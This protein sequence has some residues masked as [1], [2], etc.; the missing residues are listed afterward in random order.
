MFGAQGAANLDNI[1]DFSHAEGDKIDISALLG[2]AQ[3]TADSGSIANYVHFATSGN[4]L[5][6]Q[7]D[8]SGSGAF[9]GG[10]HDVVQLAAY[11]VSNQHIVDVVFNGHDHQVAV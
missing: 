8:T 7:V 4:D 9:S 1:L 6:L 11:A 5:L 10:S 3:G 2:G